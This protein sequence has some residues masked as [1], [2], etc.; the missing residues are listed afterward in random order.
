MIGSA[1][2]PN[3]KVLEVVRAATMTLNI[4]GEWAAANVGPGYV[5]PDNKYAVLPVTQFWPP[6]G[7]IST[8]EP[9][10]A[11]AGNK[12]SIIET[13]ATAVPPPRQR[14]VIPTNPVYLYNI[15]SDAAN[16]ERHA[17]NWFNNICYA[18][19]EKAGG[20]QA[21]P[22]IPVTGAVTVARLPQALRAGIGAR[23]M[24]TDATVTTFMSVVQGGGTNIVPVVSDG[25]QWLIG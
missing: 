3:N 16:Y 22:Y 23:L 9:S 11:L 6:Q 4:P 1:D 8:G 17:L 7:Q 12:R 2:L 20:G 24:V 14:T 25:K 15:N 19:N 10:Y 5:T 18:R 13:Y 21:R